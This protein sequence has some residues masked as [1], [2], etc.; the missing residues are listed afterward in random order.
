MRQK[1]SANIAGNRSCTTPS[2]STS[3]RTLRRTTHHRRL[4]EE[5]V[6][7]H[8][9]TLLG[10]RSGMSFS[11]HQTAVIDQD[12][13]LSHRDHHLPVASSRMRRMR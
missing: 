3:E 9:M 10:G 11:P 13:R 7:D 5:A 2:T 4:H 1:M 12:R 6:Q 8:W